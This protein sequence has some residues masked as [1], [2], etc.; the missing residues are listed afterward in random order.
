M[1]AGVN[2]VGGTAHQTEDCLTFF[3]FFFCWRFVHPVRTWLMT[4]CK[5][6]VQGHADEL[7]TAERKRN[8]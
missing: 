1:T 8:G 3:R 5:R 7:A 6:V 2:E 4:C